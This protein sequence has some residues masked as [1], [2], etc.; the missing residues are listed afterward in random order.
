MKNTGAQKLI[1]YISIGVACICLL[2]GIKEI[3]QGYVS[4]PT[5]LAIVGG[6][7]TTLRY[8]RKENLNPF[9]KLFPILKDD[10][11]LKKQTIKEILSLVYAISQ[12]AFLG[13]SLGFLIEWLHGLLTQQV[14]QPEIF[15]WLCIGSLASIIVSRVFLEMYSNI[16]QLSRTLEEYLKQIK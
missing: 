7:I 16:Y 10:Y 4:I 3:G 15:L 8:S 12:G 2:I 9:Q 5:Y 13:S 6:V 14:F 1:I 11:T